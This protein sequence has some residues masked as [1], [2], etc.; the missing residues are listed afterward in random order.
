MAKIHRTALHLHERS[1]EAESGMFTVG[2]LIWVSRHVAD[3]QD[4]NLE[5]HGAFSIDS[6]KNSA[7]EVIPRGA[8]PASCM[9]RKLDCGDGRVCSAFPSAFDMPCKLVLEAGV[10]IN[11]DDEVIPSESIAEVELLRRL[12]TWLQVETHTFPE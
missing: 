5:K 3:V 12:L 6:A 2:W 9:D 1:S 4:H 11:L 7:G 10:L 8:S